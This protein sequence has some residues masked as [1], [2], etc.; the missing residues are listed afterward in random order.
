MRLGK[1]PY[2]NPVVGGR[3]IN[4]VLHDYACMLT[5]MNKGFGLGFTLLLR[6]LCA[7]PFREC[8]GEGFSRLIRSLRANSGGMRW[9]RGKGGQKN[10]NDNT[11]E[12]NSRFHNQL[13][14]EAGPPSR[15][16]RVVAVAGS[17]WR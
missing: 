13:L 3:K 6:W 9:N 17:C 2:D 12:D 7:R 16:R 5:N 1:L 4:L 10:C 14:C 15:S 8:D 11:I